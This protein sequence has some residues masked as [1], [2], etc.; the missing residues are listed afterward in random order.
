MC[1]IYKMNALSSFFLMCCIVLS[2]KQSPNNVQSENKWTK[3]ISFDNY[4]LPEVD[5]I[6][7]TVKNERFAVDLFNNF[8]NNDSLSFYNQFINLEEARKVYTTD[9]EEYLQHYDT[10][11]R[12]RRSRCFNKLRQKAIDDGFDWQTATIQK[13]TYDL[14]D[15]EDNKLFL[16]VIILINNKNKTYELKAPDCVYTHH[17]LK[18]VQPI[19]WQ[20]YSCW[21]IL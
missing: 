21:M 17:G 15:I 19:H 3:L 4:L 20:G 8:K 10:Q 13:I 11:L 9:S 2:C 6:N 18:I 16:K 12:E 5:S 1:K 7:S 14:F